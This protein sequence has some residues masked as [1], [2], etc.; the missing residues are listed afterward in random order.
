MTPSP[1]ADILAQEGCRP[2]LLT[3]FKEVPLTATILMYTIQVYPYAPWQITQCPRARTNF[4]LANGATARSMRQEAASQICRRLSGGR[5]DKTLRRIDPAQ[6]QLRQHDPA[7][8]RDA[9]HEKG[10]MSPK[11]SFCDKITSR[12][13][14]Q[15]LG[16]RRLAL[17]ADRTSRRSA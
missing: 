13:N 12:Q 5:G 10:I 14:P 2:D 6:I 4:R 17:R 3:F 15:P 8:T 11:M 16:N 1:R 9:T 7:T